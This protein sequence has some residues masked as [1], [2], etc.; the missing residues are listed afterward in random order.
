MENDEYSSAFVYRPPTIDSVPV[1]INIRIAK[2]LD[3]SIIKDE[4]PSI[5]ITSYDLVELKTISTGEQIKRLRKFLC[6]T[7]EEFADLL[8]VEKLCVTRWETNMRKCKGPAL[9]L[10]NI[11]SENNLWEKYI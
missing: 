8:H 1:E 11:L 7:Q 2:E 4:D 5:E 6:L 3:Q 9:R 10:I